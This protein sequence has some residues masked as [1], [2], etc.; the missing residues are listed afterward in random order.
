M[1]RKITSIIIVVAATLL[2]GLPGLAGLCFGSMALAGSFM[3]DNGVPAE[4]IPLVIGSAFMILGLSLSCIAIPTG[5]GIWAWWI[6]KPKTTN[7]AE[8]IIPD[9]DF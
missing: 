1:D 3:P 7:L 2:C 8:I 6:R 4:D 9:D 5:I